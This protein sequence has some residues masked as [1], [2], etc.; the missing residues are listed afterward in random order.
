MLATEE[1]PS[2]TGE[3]PERPSLL[4]QWPQN[5]RMRHIPSAAWMV[6]KLDGDLRRRIEK[7]WLPYADLAA[8]D[9]RH[10]VLEAEFRALCR[11]IDRVA[12]VARHHHRGAQHP[13]NDLGSKLTWMIGQAVASLHAADN[14]TFGKR[15]P[16]QTFERSN[17]EPLW[18]AM[19]SVIEHV[20]RLIPL[21]REIEPD[22]DEQLY[23]GLVQ[24]QEPLRRDPIALS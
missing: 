13:P 22:I 8:S 7:L 24:L 12:A 15:L 9:P 11:S 2:P 4:E 23:E 3:R 17:S 19:L 18:A 1:Q 20:Q 5:E 21:I 16:F 14:D 10:S 6:Q